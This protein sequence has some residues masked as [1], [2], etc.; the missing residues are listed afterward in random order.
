MLGVTLVWSLGRR[1]HCPSDRL[2]VLG[3]EPDPSSRLNQARGL[4]KPTGGGPPV[5]VGEALFFE[6]TGR[7]AGGSGVNLLRR[8]SPDCTRT[9]DTALEPGS[10]ARHLRDVPY[11]GR[12]LMPRRARCALSG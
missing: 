6:L 10:E 9:V 1:D 12:S 5:I 2:G 4:A 11:T 8:A 3:C 7:A